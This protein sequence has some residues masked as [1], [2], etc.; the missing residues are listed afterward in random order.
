MYRGRP[1][2]HAATIGILT[3]AGALLAGCSNGIVPTPTLV[4][5]E[6]GLE[7]T[8]QAVTDFKLR[9]LV[10]EETEDQKHVNAAGV[11]EITTA[12]RVGVLERQREETLAR[13]VEQPCAPNISTPAYG[14]A[15]DL[16]DETLTPSFSAC[17]LPKPSAKY[18]AEKY[19]CAA[20]KRSYDI[21]RIAT[22]CDDYRETP[23]T[24]ARNS[25]DVDV[26]FDVSGPGIS[27]DAS[28]QDAV[29]EADD[30]VYFL[31]AMEPEEGFI[32]RM[33]NE[34][35][36]T[37]P[38]HPSIQG[39]KVERYTLTISSSL[40]TF[41]NQQLDGKL[42]EE[43]ESHCLGAGQ[44]LAQQF[45]GSLAKDLIDLV[46]DSTVTQ[47]YQ[48]Y[49]LDARGVADNYI[50]SITDTTINVA[51]E[52]RDADTGLPLERARFVFSGLDNLIFDFPFFEK[53]YLAGL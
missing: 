45:A 49:G 8:T 15:A 30:D 13:T 2:A 11:K 18:V 22:V 36:T 51:L 34:L 48:W 1:A 44:R 40:G 32:E 20:G 35:I 43:A 7:Y 5:N 41:E 38:E 52:A 46:K 42:M 47:T 37:A 12:S 19:L 24:Y 31:T 23:P 21:Y 6:I 17:A 33:L 16:T 39:G 28:G 9:V 29:I 3:A 4:N 14:C 25:E 50:K 53:T 27:I 26:D 10:E